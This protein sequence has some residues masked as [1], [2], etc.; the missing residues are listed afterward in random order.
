MTILQEKHFFAQSNLVFFK[1]DLKIR[2]Y[3]KSE[4]TDFSVYEARN[5]NLLFFTFS[6][7]FDVKNKIFL[8][9]VQNINFHHQ[10]YHLLQNIFFAIY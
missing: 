10:I 6:N 3:E 1:I 7:I 9:K 5:K 8:K 2:I 4:I